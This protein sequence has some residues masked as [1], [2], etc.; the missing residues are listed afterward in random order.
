MTRRRRVI[1]TGCRIPTVGQS[2]P[3]SS[4]KI[5]RQDSNIIVYIF[6]INIFARAKDAPEN[7]SD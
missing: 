5:S 6:F 4:I 3:I 2:Q 1:T 7:W